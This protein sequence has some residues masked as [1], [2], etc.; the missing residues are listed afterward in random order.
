[1]GERGSLLTYGHSL[2][3]PAQTP[4]ASWKVSGQVLWQLNAAL[5][6]LQPPL[7]AA[8]G[9]PHVLCDCTSSPPADS[10]ACS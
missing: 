2:V 7:L 10:G 5:S 3:R 6:S 4:G 8:Q 1:M 9:N